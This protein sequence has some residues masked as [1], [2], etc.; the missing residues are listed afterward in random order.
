M[1]LNRETA[2][3]IIVILIV[4]VAALSHVRYVKKGLQDFP[5][6]S[7]DD[8][9][10]HDTRF[11]A[12]RQARLDGKIAGVVGFITEP[13]YEDRKRSTS[14]RRTQ[15]AAA[16]LLVKDSVDQELI[17]GDFP[18][19]VPVLPAGRDYELLETCPGQV[20]LYR[21]KE[22]SVADTKNIPVI[23]PAPAELP[24]VKVGVSE[25]R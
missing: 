17:V 24:A 18:S 10:I 4:M 11:A 9:T 7:P 22:M 3:K 8:T 13:S 16:P 23:I 2:I 1:R 25:N 14:Y 15:Y 5:Y 21:R 20:Y 6:T 12:L 19:G